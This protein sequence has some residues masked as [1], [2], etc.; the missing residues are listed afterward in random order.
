VK[1]RRLALLGPPLF[2]CTLW[3]CAAIWIDGPASRPL[4][5]AL[6][7]AFALAAGTALL[8]RHG[9]LAFGALFALVVGWWLSIPPSNDRAWEPSVARLPSATFEGDLVTIENV[10]NFDYR[11]QED[12]DE[13]WEI[14]SYDL[15][16]LRGLDIFLSYWGSPLIAHTIMSW[17]FEDGRHLAI[18]IETRREERESYSALLGFFRQFELYYVVADERDV[19]RLRTNYRDEN[20][21][22]YRLKRPTEMARAVL[23]DYL[24]EINELAEEARWYNALLHNCTT[25]IRHHLQNVAASNPW[26]WRILVNG[27]LDELGYM[28]Q[29]IDTSLPF[30]ELRRRSRIDERAR[31]ADDDAA[32]SRRIREGLPGF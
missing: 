15:S 24:E 19:V 8:L 1:I 18:S 28:R 14:R 4:A 6:A 21:Y 3:A 30:E 7:V 2:A 16:G 5:G 11:T 12:F 26:D 32:F 13:R 31:A 22:L 17:D 20:V 25:M 23:I 29:T 27:K 9:L 10:R